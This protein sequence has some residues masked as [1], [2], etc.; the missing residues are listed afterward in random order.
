MVFSRPLLTLVLLTAVLWVS[1]PAL[2][3]QA[4]GPGGAEEDPAALV[5]LTLEELI[6]RFGPPES[7]YAVRGLE[8]WQDDVVFVYGNRDFYIYKD[9]VWQL[10]LNSVYGITV[11]ESRSVAALI[12]EDLQLFDSYGVLPLT[13]RSWPLSLRLEWGNTNVI[14]AIYIYRPDF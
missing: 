6:A 14:S 9:R 12:F 5:G 3:S 2:W 10:G 7:V 4:N 13:G 8:S 11:G 1:A